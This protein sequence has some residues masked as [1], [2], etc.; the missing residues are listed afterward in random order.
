[1]RNNDEKRRKPLERLAIFLLK[2]AA[3][4]SGPE[5]GKVNRL[6]RICERLADPQNRA[7]LR[8]QR[9][10]HNAVRIAATS[11]FLLALSLATVIAYKQGFYLEE[12]KAAA[13]MGSK[14]I[15]GAVKGSGSLFEPQTLREWKDLA[16]LLLLGFVPSALLS[17]FLTG[18]SP[19]I[20]KSRD[21]SRQLKKSGHHEQDSEAIALWTPVGVMVE[22]QNTTKKSLLDDE[23]L[24]SQLNLTPGRASQDPDRMDLIFISSGFAL[25][26]KYAYNAAQLKARAQ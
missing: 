9:R 22:M 17:H 8:R 13:A 18:K 25:E 5:F 4:V 20:K 10:L 12:L 2:M 21:L 26:K 24:W 14:G 19:I 23:K 3:R 11:P 6:I 7:A 15:L 16:V 1:M